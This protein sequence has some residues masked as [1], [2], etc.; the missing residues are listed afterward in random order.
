M[1]GNETA[2]ATRRC[3]FEAGVLPEPHEEDARGAVEDPSRLPRD[4]G[5]QADLGEIGEGSHTHTHTIKQQSHTHNSVT[6]THKH[7]THIHVNK[8][9]TY[10]S[11]HTHTH[12]HT[13]ITHT[14]THTYMYACTCK[15]KAHVFLTHYREGHNQ[16]ATPP[17]FHRHTCEGW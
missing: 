8:S 9:H 5:L 12:T 7:T 14:C 10:T 1:S 3:T 17:V 16:S 4:R 15:K 13:T 11:I 6:H 2:A